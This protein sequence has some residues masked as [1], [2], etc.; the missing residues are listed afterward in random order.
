MLVEY[1][2]VDTNRLRNYAEQIGAHKS[3][4]KV[5]TLKVGLAITGPSVEGTQSI[6]EQPATIHQ[7]VQGVLNHL[8]A[9]DLL[10]TS[11]PW[12]ESEAASSRT[13][14]VLE[15]MRARKITFQVDQIVGLKGLRELG[16]WVSNPSE[17][18]SELWDSKT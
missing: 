6:S 9:S 2:F 16:V 8:T 13:P 14:F 7:M 11:R 5:P 4:K 18:P 12:S 15:T 10:L 17:R 3:S 1:L